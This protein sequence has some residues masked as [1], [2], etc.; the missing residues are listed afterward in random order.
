MKALLVC[1]EYPP[2]TY[3]SFSR[4]LPYIDRR[5]AMPPLGLITVAAML[6]QHWELRLIDMNISPLRDADL[7]WADVVMTSTMVVQAPSHTEVVVRC[8]RLGVPV[9]AG[10]PFPSGSPERLEGVDHL[11][12]GEAEG[13]LT[14]LVEDLERGEA[15]PIY[16]AGGKPDV[17]ES[18]IPRF[19]L[20]EL[21]AYAS[22]AVQH[23]RGCPFACEFCDIWTLYGRKMRIKSAERMAAELDALYAGGWRGS[24]FFVDDNFIGNPRRAKESLQALERWQKNHGFPFQFF[25]EASVNLGTDD[26]LM[27]HMRDAGFNFV[28]LGIESPSDESL[29]GANKPLN[30]KLDLLQVVRRIQAHG[31]E[32]S[33][34]FIVGF[35]EDT[36]DI[37]DRQIEFIEEAAIPM[38]MVGILTAVE[39]TVLYERLQD[40][41][42]LLSETYGNNTHS[43]EPNFVTRMPAELLVTGYKRVMST[44][45]D[46]TLANYFSRCRRLF[47]RLGPNRCFTRRIVGYELRA[48]LRSLATIPTRRFGRQ[49]LRF[50][51][52]SLFRHPARFPEAVRLAIQGFHLEA[53]TREALTCDRIRDESMRLAVRFREWLAQLGGGSGRVPQ[54]LAERARALR[55]LRRKIRRLAPETRPV[56][57]TAYRGLVKRVD[58]LIEEHVPTAARAFAAGSARLASLRDACRRDAELIRARYLE[59]CEGAKRG[60]ADLDRELQVLYEARC[61]ILKRARRGV[62]QLPREYRLLGGIELQA[63]RRSLDELL[64]EVALVP[65][66]A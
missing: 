14:K 3:W 66:R 6:P 54:L 44:L 52:W 7:V 40:E 24:V 33:S 21:D 59:A 34:G 9:V 27:A 35:D 45:Y 49:Y 61:D 23:S 65:V 28:F 17:D 32:V 15:K 38:A 10:G 31:I 19:D 30:V 22:M 37:F 11:F 57:V 60:V 25:T 18:P 36:H 12:V 43:F 13:A 48:L 8:K 2:L 64:P 42:R 5:A 51:L 56:G 53:I 4:A 41:G 55:Q 29:A 39:G 47:D 46:P 16:H 50:L 63:L 26:E 58:A 20:L 62:R 1:P